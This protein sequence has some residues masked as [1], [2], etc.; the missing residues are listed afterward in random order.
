MYEGEAMTSGVDAPFGAA[1]RRSVG[2]ATV[3]GELWGAAAQDWAKIQEVTAKPVWAAALDS[4]IVT[5]GTRLLDAG[6]GAGGA[7]MLGI[8]RGAN[9]HGLDASAEL[10][11][12]ARRRVPGAVFRVG[13]IEELPYAEDSFDA[14]IACSSVQYCNDPIAAL[15]ELRRVC[16]PEGRVTIAVWGR[17][18]D[19]DMRDVFAAVRGVLPDPPDELGPFA[20][21]QSGALEELLASAGLRAVMT[22]QVDA[23]FEYPD[24]S[25][26]WRG[27]RSAGPL[28]AALREVGEATL[29]TAVEKALVAHRTKA[30]RIRLD[31]R[32][33]V[34]T[35]IR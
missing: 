10:I 17:A 22:E 4:A 12:I 7:A 14:V 20:L 5:T 30:G 32:F 33:R 26:A 3:Q 21:S 19:C 11:A 24:I 18:A 1:L 2:S 8:A 34:V 31:N 16:A 28:Q 6:C 29:K 23:P 15:R 13:E 27:Q 25:T 9:V 35:A